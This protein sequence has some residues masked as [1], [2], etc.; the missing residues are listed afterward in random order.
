MSDWNFREPWGL[1]LPDNCLTREDKLRKN[2]TQETCPD[3]D[4]TRIRCATGAYATACST[5]V[6]I[7]IN[8]VI[9]F[10]MHVVRLIP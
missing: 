3:R 7:L 1:K 4:R 8:M 5:A 10:Q 6:D 9:Y 2:L